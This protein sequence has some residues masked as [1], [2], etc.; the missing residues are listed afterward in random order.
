M[1]TITK[2]TLQFLKD[3]K[4]NNDRDWFTKNKSNYNKA[5]QEFEQFVDELIQSISGFDPEIVH[6]TA[7]NTVFRIY[8]DVRF[9]NDKSPYKTNFGA[10]ITGAANKSELHS[11]A[12]YY[13]H[14]EPG[15]SFLAGGAYLPTGNW[16]KAIRKEID[17][18][19]DELKRILRSK[20]FKATFGEME[21]EKLKTS[22]RDYPSD[23]PEIE[24]LRYKS[25]LAVHNISDEQILADDFLKKCTDVFKALYPFDQFLNNALR[26]HSE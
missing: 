2:P 16:L 14:L 18:N 25:F 21:G 22:P 9:S 13:I 6:Q 23:H 5:K 15:Q 8:R 24:L 12:G 26:K 1:Q 19:T 4:Q 7:K 11:R 3:L 17:E 20:S 10:H